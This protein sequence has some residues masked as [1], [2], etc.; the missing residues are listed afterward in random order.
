M[1]TLH[2]PFTQ[3]LPLSNLPLRGA[4]SDD[5]L[6]VIP[7]AGILTDNGEVIAVGEFKELRGSKLGSNI[8]IREVEGPAIA[9]PG[10]IDCHTHLCFGGSRAQDYAARNAG[11][12]YQQI[13]AAGGG[14]KDTMRKTRSATDLQLRQ[15]LTARLDRHLHNGV[16]TIEVKSGY[17]LSVEQEL[18]L[19]HIIKS[20]GDAH[21]ADVI[22][23]CLAAHVIP[24]E[25]ED[26]Q[27][28]LRTILEGIV[29]IIQ[30]EW[31]TYRFDIFVEEGTFTPRNSRPFLEE[32]KSHGFD[33]TVHGDQF[34]T[35][36]SQL[37]ID[38]GARSVDHLEASGP[39]EI[40]ALGKS[41]TVAVALPG[42]TLGLGC[43][44]APARRLLDANACLAIASD[45]NPGSA[46]M[47]DLLTQA[48]ILGAFEKLT[49]AEVF[50]GLT[51]RAAAALDLE[52]RGRLAAGQK[53]DFVSFP[54]GDYREILYHQGQLKPNRVWK[55]GSPVERGRRHP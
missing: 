22:P 40:T 44:F 7:D 6:K 16:T 41:S 14:I 20:T 34:T 2:G 9:L 10:F 54:T 3:L 51:L 23:T 45:W 49:A 53:A 42:A 1:P 21:S 4:L 29:P 39:S 5:Q 38:V 36:G 50:A 55:N 17:G 18:R 43:P 31:L 28:W 48:S 26:E 37:A 47:G 24:P 19:L 30:A 32:L 13:G 25:A 33:L 27:D 15:G 11:Q 12:T 52:D 35:G 46:P 8:T